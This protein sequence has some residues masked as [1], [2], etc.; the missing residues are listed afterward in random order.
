MSTT[1]APGFLAISGRS[2]RSTL[3]IVALG[4]LFERPPDDREIE[5]RISWAASLAPG[6]VQRAEP[7]GDVR[8][9][10]FAFGSHVSYGLTPVG[11]VDQWVVASTKTTETVSRSAPSP[12]RP[13]EVP[14]G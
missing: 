4:Q 12:T 9:C 14:V 10:P 7:D 5:T 11:A 8:R 2:A 1:G 6:H 3:R 13:P